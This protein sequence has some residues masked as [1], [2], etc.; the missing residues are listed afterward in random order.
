MK[1]ILLL[2]IL[3]AGLGFTAA[4]QSIQ[5]KITLNAA[6]LSNPDCWL[7]QGTV[8]NN[9][10]YLHSGLCTSDSAKCFDS[11]CAGGSSS[12]WEHVI[13]NWGLD[14]GVGLMT[15][16]G[17]ARWSI[18]MVPT[19]F[20][21]QLGS[22]PYT[23]GLVF[24]SDD[25]TVTG[26]DETCSDIFIKGINTSNPQVV[27]CANTAFTAVT[28]ERTVLAGVA[29]GQYLTGFS[30]SPNPTTQRSTVSYQLTRGAKNLSV[31]V[32]SSVGMEVATLFQGMQAPGAH[33]LTWDGH[34][35]AGQRVADGLYHLVMTD[36]D[37]LLGTEKL[38]MMQ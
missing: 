17:N 33:Q 35:G 38:V 28:V 31:K 24:R 15:F 37:K 22:T 19:V 29:D 25:G 13:G 30:V 1:R 21:N 32:Y 20:Y 27:N 3:A 2:G 5:L 12:P 7:N 26:K 16:E 8:N 14:D 23:I 4:A 9:K 34:N 10:V 18:T 36:G 11:I 6:Q